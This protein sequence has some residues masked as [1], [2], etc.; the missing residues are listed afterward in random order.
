MQEL[1]F[2]EMS[3][4]EQKLNYAQKD[5]DYDTRNLQKD[6]NTLQLI[7]KNKLQ[8]HFKNTPAK[9][10]LMRLREEVRENRLRWETIKAFWEEAKNLSLKELKGHQGKKFIVIA[11][12]DKRLQEM[13]DTKAQEIRLSAWTIRSHETKHSEIGAFNYSLIGHILTIAKDKDIK[14]SKNKE[15]HIVYFAKYG[16]SYQAVFKTTKDKK[17][18]YLQS[19]IIKKKGI[20]RVSQTLAKGDKYPVNIVTSSH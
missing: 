16:T 4:V 15:R 1:G 18:I 14:F 19:L 17:E 9:E 3:Q 13:L 10:A 20:K 6:D 2:K 5:W 8:K 11:Q 7:I 12:A